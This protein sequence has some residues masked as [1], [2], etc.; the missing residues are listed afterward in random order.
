MRILIIALS[1][2]ALSGCANVYQDLKSPCGP[3]ASLAK[4]PCVHIPFDQA[5]AETQIVRKA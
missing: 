2:L 1:V 5:D 4:N 3:S